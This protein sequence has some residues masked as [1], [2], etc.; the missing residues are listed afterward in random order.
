V[1]IAS[2]QG[3][4]TLD[5]GSTSEFLI[6]PGESSSQWGATTERLGLTVDAVGS[7]LAAVGDGD[8]PD[9]DAGC[10]VV[11]CGV[12]LDGDSW[13]GKCGDHAD[14]EFRADEEAGR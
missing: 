5:D 4:I 11:G 7:M 2:I 13:N 12:E 9:D 8:T 1:V 6:T 14:E 3:V 10:S